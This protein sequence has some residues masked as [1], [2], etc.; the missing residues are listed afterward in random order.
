[1]PWESVETRKYASNP[2]D[3]PVREGSRVATGYMRALPRLRGGVNHPDTGSPPDGARPA[4][5]L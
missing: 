1:M 4:C 3:T 2:P 5:S